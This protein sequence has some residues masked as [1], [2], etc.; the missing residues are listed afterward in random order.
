MAITNELSEHRIYAH[1]HD[2]ERLSLWLHGIKGIIFKKK[3]KVEK[4]GKIYYYKQ[5]EITTKD[6]YTHHITLFYD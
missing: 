2:K 5:I 1:I 4:D 3:K 6:N